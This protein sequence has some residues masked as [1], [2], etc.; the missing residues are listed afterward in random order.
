M[1][2][3]M[4]NKISFLIVLAALF[5]LNTY[6]MQLPEG[7]TAVSRDQQIDGK[8]LVLAKQNIAGRDVINLYRYNTNNILDATFGLTGVIEVNLG[9][10]AEPLSISVQ[11]DGKILVKALVDGQETQIRF[12]SPGTIDTTFGEGGIKKIAP[13]LEKLS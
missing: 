8:T 12:N 2:K 3:I 6:S 10:P 5:A 1:E 11:P 4:K 13:E 9:Q 7:A